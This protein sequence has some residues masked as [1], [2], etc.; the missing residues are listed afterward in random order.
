MGLMETDPCA[1]AAQSDGTEGVAPSTEA[2]QG[3]TD[4]CEVVTLSPMPAGTTVAARDVPP[5]PLAAVLPAA[6]LADRLLASLRAQAVRSSERWRLP[7]RYPGAL[8][9][10]S[11]VFLT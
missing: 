3:H 11:M 7:P 1:A 2:R 9:I 10:Q 8:R 5:S 6:I 4:C